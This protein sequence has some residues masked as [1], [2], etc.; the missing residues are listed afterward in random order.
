MSEYFRLVRRANRAAA[1]TALANAR[2]LLV[3]L[4]KVRENYRMR[5]DEFQLPIVAA[6]YLANS[7]VTA[8]RKKAFLM[9]SSYRRVPPIGPLMKELALM[10]TLVASYTRW[11]AAG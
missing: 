9:G 10:A 7:V 5:D 1:D 8:A 4:Q 11:S 3:D 2:A 6:R